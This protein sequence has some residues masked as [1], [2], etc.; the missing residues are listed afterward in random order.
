MDR[1]ISKLNPGTFPGSC[2][3]LDGPSAIFA[4][5]VGA[6]MVGVNL[7]NFALTGLFPRW[8]RFFSR[9]FIASR[10]LPFSANTPRWRR[11]FSRFVNASRLIPF[12]VYNLILVGAVVTDERWH[13]DPLAVLE[14]AGLFGG[15]GIFGIVLTIL[16]PSLRRRAGQGL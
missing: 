3:M 1:V 12:I 11:F 9:F 2:K 10:L 5:E 8:R 4:I 16:I 13:P 6:L 7:M 14:I 15:L